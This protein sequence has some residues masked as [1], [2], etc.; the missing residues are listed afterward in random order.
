MKALFLILYLTIFSF[1]QE[2]KFFIVS[3]SL[4]INKTDIKS[5]NIWESK[6]EHGNV[7]IIYSHTGVNKIN[8]YLK[9]HKLKKLSLAVGN[10]II[11]FG[12][13][14]KE[15]LLEENE[16]IALTTDTLEDAETFKNSLF[17]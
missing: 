15:T 17:K 3:D 5:I 6:G 12:S 2:V 14:I 11:F 9:K 8:S 4:I 7:D 16:I 10:K 13:K 1:S